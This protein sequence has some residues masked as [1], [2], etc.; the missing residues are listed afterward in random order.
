M[1]WFLVTWISW[2]CPGGPLGGLVPAAARPA[3]CRPEPRFE[4]YD[5]ALE[6]RARARVR[7]LGGGAELRRCRGLRCSGNLADWKT[8]VEFKE[9]P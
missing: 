5:P 9:A 1:I 8:D 6:R 2:A 7:E 4:V 3:V